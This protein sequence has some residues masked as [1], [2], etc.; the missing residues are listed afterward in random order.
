M[1]A[2]EID[3]YGRRSI[4]KRD[5]T[6]FFP[7]ERTAL[8]GA[9]GGFL[10]VNKYVRSHFPYTQYFKYTKPVPIFKACFKAFK[11]AALFNIYEDRVDILRSFR[12]ENRTRF[13]F[14]EGLKIGIV[15]ASTY[16][17]GYLGTAVGSLIPIPLVG[18]I[19][20]YTVG[21][22]LGSGVGYG[23]EWIKSRTI[24]NVYPVF[25]EDKNENFIYRA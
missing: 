23:L 20:G 11:V 1:T 4:W 13:L 8:A 16:I 9:L 12:A 24:G 7:E 5:S 22:A 2:T 18:M 25:K 17:G 3:L 6:D 10:S 14:D 15:G 19:T 21:V